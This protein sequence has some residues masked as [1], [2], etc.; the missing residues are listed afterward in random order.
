MATKMDPPN[1]YC[2]PDKHYYML[3]HSL[4]EIDTKYVPIRPLG[5]GAYGV[6][7]SADNLETGDKVAIKKIGNAFENSIDALRTLREMRLLRYLQHENVVGLL[8]IMKPVGRYTFNDVYLVYEL[9]DTDLHQIIRSSQ[10]L[11]D[12]HYQFFIYQLLRGLKYIHSANVLH[13]DL[14]PGNLLLNANCDLKIADF[15][16]ARTGREKG[17]FMTEYVV[18]RWYRAPELLLSCEDYTSAID[19]WSVGCIFAEL[20]GRKP[21]FPGKNYINQ[22]KL[23]I[24]VIGSPKES[25]LGF[26]SNHKARSYI[27]SLPPTPRV[28]LSRLYPHANPQA[29]QLIERMLAFD[30]KERITV[31]EALDHPYFNLVHDNHAGD[32]Y[33][34]RPDN[35]IPPDV[36]EDQMVDTSSNLREY[37]WREMCYYHPQ[38]INEM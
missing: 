2:P 11:T 7:C 26:I 19:I 20:L 13:R 32:V 14:K 17:Q 5:K 12:E 3:W 24:D 27:R 22:L 15:G 23:I 21:I 6:V 1:G 30:P 10:P 35:I 4:F 34:F 33:Q 28:P 16:L 38:A 9:M 36:M 8:D 37:V 18:T 25:Q 31:S 29:L